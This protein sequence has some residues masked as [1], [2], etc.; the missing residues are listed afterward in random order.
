MGKKRE[1]MSG[2]QANLAIKNPSVAG[3]STR[4]IMG[5]FNIYFHTFLIGL[6]ITIFKSLKKLR[7]SAS[8]FAF[9]RGLGGN[10]EA[11][12]QLMFWNKQKKM[13]C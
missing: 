2:K 5:L 10:T 8:F 11:C 1:E 4:N 9:A 3:N 6:N 13:Y 12:F 7:F